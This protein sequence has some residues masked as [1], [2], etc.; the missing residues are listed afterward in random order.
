MPLVNG[1]KSDQISIA[2]RGLQ[3]GDGLFET[4]A[5][6][7]GRPCLWDQHLTRLK[8]GCQQLGIS[9]P[10]PERLLDELLSEIGSSP[11]DRSIIKIIFT[12]GEG[13][14]GY[15]PPEIQ[16]PTRIVQNFCWSDNSVDLSNNG[17]QTR[18]CTTRLG[19]NPQLAGI[20]HLNRL[21][22]ILARDEWSDP[23]IPE[24]IM[25]DQAENVIEGTQS[26][27]FLMYK[28]RV[29]TPDL[30]RCGVKGI[31]RDQ[32]LGEA[33]SLGIDTETREVTIDDLS[34]ADG[35]YFSNSITGLWPV[36]VLDGKNYDCNAMPK[37]L[38]D[39]VMTNCFSQKML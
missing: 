10:D 7:G 22:Q 14:R 33:E 11:D 13:G 31:V 20:K 24:G 1:L 39:T 17:A 26:N 16:S 4:I 8:I 29:I 25:L 18:L 5:I 37:K 28:G 23:E 30:S 21:E 38:R 3:Y 2:D 36:T 34:R 9:P 6:V 12:R 27:I 32:L 15:R 35:I 19:W